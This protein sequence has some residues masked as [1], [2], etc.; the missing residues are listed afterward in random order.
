[1][2]NPAQVNGQSRFEN[3]LGVYLKVKPVPR[4][5]IKTEPELLKYTLG[6][7]S[8]ATAGSVRAY[9]VTA[10]VTLPSIPANWITAAGINAAAMLDGALHQTQNL[11]KLGLQK[12]LIIHQTSRGIRI[13][14]RSIHA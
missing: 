3:L 13:R 5:T 4:L 7:I 14:S 9:S 1:M 12:P 10:A 11:L 8:P 6:T 2:L